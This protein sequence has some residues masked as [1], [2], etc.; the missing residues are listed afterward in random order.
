MKILIAAYACYPNLGREPG[1]GW[2]N[3]LQ[4]AQLGHEVWVITLPSSVPKCEEH[5]A[6]KLLPN[7]HFVAVEHPI[8]KDL[9]H[10]RFKY[11]HQFR[12]LVWKKNAEKTA[13]QLD[14]KHEFDIIHHL[15]ISSLQGGPLSS[16]FNK[17]LIFG[18]VGGGQT[19]PVSFKNYFFDGWFDETLRSLISCKLIVFNPFLRKA[20]NRTT[21]VLATNQDTA[22]LAQKLGARNVELF[23]DSGLP[24]EYYPSELPKK[25]QSQELRL[26]WLSSI[27]ARKGL[28]LAL[29][30]LSQVNASIP[31][32]LTIIGGGTLDCYVQ[33]WIKQFNL[34]TKVEYLGSIPWTEVKDVYSNSDVFLFTSLRDSYG[35]VL[36]EAMSQGLP[37][38]TLNHHGARDFVPDNAG[39]KVPVNNPDETVLALAQAVEYMFK[40]PDVRLKMSQVAYEFAKKQ[41]WAQRAVIITK[42]YEDILKNYSTAGVTK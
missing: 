3:A 40:N 39:I 15:T 31:F 4:L 9:P 30:A 27:E 34:E 22:R 2:N 12:Y 32:K 41:S 10:G 26:L 8:M 19:A 42:Y 11:L 24:P 21:L 17:P 16:I 25:V 20:L 13:L 7:L 28:F 33:Q 35:S 29:E 18:P 38:I 37:V 6:A 1:F 5:P 36:I 14:K 23:L